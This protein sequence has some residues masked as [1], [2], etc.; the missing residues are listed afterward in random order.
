MIPQRKRCEA[1]SDDHDKELEDEGKTE[2]DSQKKI[3][4][5]ETDTEA[6]EREVVNGECEKD[7]ITILKEDIV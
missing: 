7:N 4:L 2:D 3:K 6:S 5:S 1:G